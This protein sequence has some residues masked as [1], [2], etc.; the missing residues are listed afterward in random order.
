MYGAHHRR[1]VLRGAWLT[2]WTRYFSAPLYLIPLILRFLRC[3]S[4]SPL[5]F[6]FAGISAF[7]E[8]I[9]PPGYFS[10]LAS[11]AS[12]VLRPA[13]AG[14]GE[15]ISPRKPCFRPRGHDPPSSNAFRIYW[16]Q[17]E[18]TGVASRGGESRGWA[19]PPPSR[20]QSSTSSHFRVSISFHTRRLRWWW[21]AR[22]LAVISALG[23]ILAR[24]VSGERV[25]SDDVCLLFR[26]QRPSGCARLARDEMATFC[27]ILRFLPTF[28]C[29]SSASSRAWR[30]GTCARDFALGLAF[31][32][33]SSP[34]PRDCISQ[35]ARAL[36]FI[37]CSS[38]I[39]CRLHV[40]V[41]SNA[42]RQPPVFSQ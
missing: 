33:R 17:G 2:P 8:S 18:G 5:H 1:H 20:A 32:L 7:G 26:S 3:I 28:R 21:F 42:V 14:I 29:V 24:F 25:S 19:L 38:G 35:R 11:F 27:F 41:K 12:L 31:H 34:R 10:V 37:S 4:L 13:F 30:A 9:S 22:L 16:A 15:S 6:A 23:V 40:Q 39:E 36:L